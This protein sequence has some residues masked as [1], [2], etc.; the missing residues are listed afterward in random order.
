MNKRNKD[1]GKTKVYL[2]NL[3]DLLCN[4]ITTMLSYRD[5][6]HNGYM[7]IVVNRSIEALF[8]ILNILFKK[9]LIKGPFLCLHYCQSYAEMFKKGMY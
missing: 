6:H 1:Y 4:T 5:G 7:D 3:R 9:L 8:K 2:F